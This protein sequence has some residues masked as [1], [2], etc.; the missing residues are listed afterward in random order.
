MGDL[1][2]GAIG[3]PTP[4]LLRTYAW[5]PSDTA[6]DCF[7]VRSACWGDTAEVLAQPPPAVG[8]RGPQLQRA[9]LESLLAVTGLPFGC[10]EV[11][12][13]K[14]PG[15]EA[16]DGSESL[17]DLDARGRQEACRRFLQACSRLGLRL[18]PTCKQAMDTLEET[19]SGMPPDDKIF[20]VAKQA[21]VE[22]L[23]R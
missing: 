18:A 7:V 16:V 19:A 9:A 8:P 15:L 17:A 22:E 21:A 12:A 13:S 11:L 20:D 4:P 5:D 10:E 3:L 2:V 6:T 14:A 1:C 23:V